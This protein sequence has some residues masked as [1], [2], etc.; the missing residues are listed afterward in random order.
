MATTTLTLTSYVSTLLGSTVTTISDSILLSGM[1]DIVNKFEIQFP[2]RLAELNTETSIYSVPVTIH[3]VSPLLRVLCNGKEAFRRNGTEHVSDKYSLKCDNGKTTY[4]YVIGNKLYIYPFFPTSN[5]YVMHGLAYG[6]DSG[7]LTWPDRLGYPLALFCA[8][9]LLFGEFSTELLSII[10]TISDAL[11]NSDLADEY[12]LVATRLLADDVELA[13][14][15]L[16]KIRTCIEEF[17][18]IAGASASVLQASIQNASL[19]LGRYATIRNRYLEYF[20]MAIAQKG[21]RE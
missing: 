12:T 8:A 9:D 7:V 13:E 15:Q 4:Y 17:S 16:A 11:V 5:E 1:E 14:A 2:E 3:N 18:A 10:T 21:E 20:G 6:V 19:L